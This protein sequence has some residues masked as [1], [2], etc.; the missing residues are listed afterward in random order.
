MPRPV[1]GERG[2]CANYTPAKLARLAELTIAWAV[3]ESTQDFPQCFPGGLA[4]I[5]SN[6]L[7]DEWTPAMFGMVPHWGDPAKLSRMTYNALGA[8]LTVS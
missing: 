7:K 5:L 4:P 8:L 6:I 1:Q 2:M 3:R